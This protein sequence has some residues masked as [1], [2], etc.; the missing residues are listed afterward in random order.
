VIIEV[1]NQ[2][3]ID[4][5]EALAKEIWTEHYTPII[6]RDQVE[7]MLARF[8]SRDA[9]SAQIKTEGYLYF[10]VEAEGAYIGY[11]GVQLK[12]EELFLSKIYIKASERGKGFGKEA[13]R[14]LE[15]LA[16]KL[17]L[18]RIALTVNKNNI[19]SIHAYE[20]MGFHNLGP[21]VQDIGNGFVMDDF[22]MEKN[23]SLSADK[24]GSAED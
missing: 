16:A 2:E 20:K 21:V 18:G 6:G 7:Y 17:N 15:N 24:K 19:K 10:L 23:V 14:V 3:Q 8:Q 22:K 4:I 11:I 1:T 13:I 12:G 9:I 5:V